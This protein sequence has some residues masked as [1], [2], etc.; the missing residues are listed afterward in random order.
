V[1]WYA[2]NAGWRRLV[3]YSPN[4]LAA[5]ID[6]PP[7]ARGLTLDDLPDNTPGKTVREWAERWHAYPQSGIPTDGVDDY[8]GDGLLLYGPPGTGKTTMA[9]IALQHV[10]AL[11]WSGKFIRTQDYYALRLAAM[12]E[13]DPSE[14]ERLQSAFDCY[15]AG[16]K[17]WRV[18]VLDDL[19]KEYST[20]SGFSENLIEDLIRSRYTDAVPTIVTTNLAPSEIEERYGAAM[21]SYIHEAFWS[22]QVKGKDFR[23]AGR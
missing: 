1:T 17:G 2:R 5:I 20:A 22:V 9:A 10:T 14:Q 21:G 7:K 19:G 8:R 6:C 12:R 15:L 4:R 11:G 3:Q 16:W 23:R 13:Q 18:M